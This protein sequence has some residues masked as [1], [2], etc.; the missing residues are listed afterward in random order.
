MAHLCAQARARL[1]ALLRGYAR[2]RHRAPA[3]DARHP[4]A[5][6]R[7]A[8]ARMEGQ[9]EGRAAGAPASPADQEGPQ[10]QAGAGVT[11]SLRPMLPDDRCFVVSGWSSSLRTSR[12]V[13]LIPMSM[14]A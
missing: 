3:R 1:G 8:G 6:R 9:T 7:D 14:W 13:A 2:R 10:D 5:R 11:L 4:P 12:D